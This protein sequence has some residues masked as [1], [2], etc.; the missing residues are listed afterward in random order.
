MDEIIRIEYEDITSERL[1]KEFRK[2]G[3]LAI[4]LSKKRAFLCC[5]LLQVAARAKAWRHGDGRN[6]IQRLVLALK[7]LLLSARTAISHVGLLDVVAFWILEKPARCW[8]EELA[9]ERYE[10]R[11][12]HRKAISTREIN[13]DD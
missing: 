6:R 1:R 10:I 9:G 2:Y 11:C 8:V 3:Y 13:A 12:A 7:G 4:P 5:E